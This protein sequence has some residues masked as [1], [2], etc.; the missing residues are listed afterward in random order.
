MVIIWASV[1]CLFLSNHAAME[2]QALAHIVLASVFA[3]GRV[4]HTVFYELRM[5]HLRTT[6]YALGLAAQLALIINAVIAS[7]RTVDRP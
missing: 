3:L 4:L 6:S 2:K 7:F 1:L 5:V